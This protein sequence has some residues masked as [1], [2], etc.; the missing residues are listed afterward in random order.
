MAQGCVPI[1]S[2]QRAIPEIIQH[3]YNGLMFDVPLT[4]QYSAVPFYQGSQGS[5]TWTDLLFEKLSDALAIDA[6]TY[7]NLSGCAVESIKTKHNPEAH[8]DSL[9]E[10]YRRVGVL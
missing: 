2:N 1:V 6:I 8:A 9:M 4:K 5:D 3:H 10:L 7:S